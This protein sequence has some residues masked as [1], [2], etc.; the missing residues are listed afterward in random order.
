MSLHEAA[1]SVVR[2][3]VSN[4]YAAF[5][6]ILSR[7]GVDPRDFALVAF[8][9]A[10]PLVGSL[11]ARDVGIP[12]VFVPRAPGTLCA[13]GAITTDILNDAVRT[14]HGRLDALDLAALA[15][16][17]RALERELLAWVDAH[18]IA[19]ERTTFRHGADM[20]YVGQSYEIE[21]PAD[22][23]WLA[24]GDRG[25]LLE[26]FHRA[27]ERVFGHADPHAPVE[28]VNLRVQLRGVRPRVPLVEV[29]AGTGAKAT[30]ARRVWL[31]GRPAQA[32]VYERAGLGRGDRVVGPAIVEQADTTV[33]VPAGDAAT[34]DRFGN[35]LIRREA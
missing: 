30:G 29:A 34:V 24:G 8:G 28:M 13:L 32:Q 11:L 35:L 18:R 3:A 15:G 16:E 22:P 26:A 33:L 1:E 5:T 17:Q 31:E 12:T 7:A 10:G 6:K 21:V 2:V 23:A 20:R 27:H 9:G 14:V 4:M 19:V 25:R